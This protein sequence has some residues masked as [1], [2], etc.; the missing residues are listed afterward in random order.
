MSR[1]ASVVA[2]V[3][4]AGCGNELELTAA[5]EGVATRENV[6]VRTR[7]VCGDGVVGEGEDCDD[8]NNA[9]D[10][11]CDARCQAPCGDDEIAIIGC[12]P[13]RTFT[14][15]YE[16]YSETQSAWVTA[17]FE[18]ETV[19]CDGLE[20]DAVEV[21][22][23]T[24]GA[25]LNVLPP[26]GGDRVC[27]A[28]CATTT[29]CGAGLVCIGAW[30]DR[31]EVADD[32]YRHP[33]GPQQVS[34]R[35][36]PAIGAGVGARC[37]GGGCGFGLSCNTTAG[38]RELRFCM[39]SGCDDNDDCPSDALCL[40]AI[41]LVTGDASGKACFNTLRLVAGTRVDNDELNACLPHA[42]LPVEFTNA[43]C[44]AGCNRLYNVCG[45]V[46]VDD[47]MERIT[48]SACRRNCL[49]GANTLFLACLEASGCGALERCTDSQPGEDWY[50]APRC[51]TGQACP[52]DW[53]CQDFGDGD[54]RCVAPNEGAL[55]REPSRTLT[56][57]RDFPSPECA[58]DTDTT[59]TFESDCDPDCA[60]STGCGIVPSAGLCRSG[61]VLFCQ[62]HRVVSIDCEARDLAC[63]YDAA[64]S[65]FDCIGGGG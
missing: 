10:D 59:C 17:S 2:L 42:V 7:P 56:L 26:S 46:F 30:A 20:G 55:S 52:R 9:E 38:V 5:G 50:C 43:R 24:D 36:L 62:T 14:D 63:G 21:A 23:C 4:L 3:W 37:S 58:E 65:R 41:N 31:P 47:R 29:E 64:Q 16:L 44:T 53:T 25:C 61:R 12:R 57:D 6:S 34:G 13:G 48:E 22:V 54:R 28:P 32:L 35:C 40:N 8:G 49:A 11:G 18:V 60:L 27:S 39:P 15:A 1:A 51:G 19:L 33:A 45:Q